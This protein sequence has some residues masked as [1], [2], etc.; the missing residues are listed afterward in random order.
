MLTPNSDYI[1]ELISIVKK[2][3][4]PSHM[5]MELQPSWPCLEKD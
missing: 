1:N 5:S 3:P 2:S 4:Y